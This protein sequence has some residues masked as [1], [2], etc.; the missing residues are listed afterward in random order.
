[1][2]VCSCPA[3]DLAK[4]T[5][6]VV[7]RAMDSNMAGQFESAEAS[8]WREIGCN[9]V[10]L[11]TVEV[12]E[13]RREAEDEDEDEEE[14][15]ERRKRFS[16]GKLPEIETTRGRIE[17][18]QPGSFPTTSQLLYVRSSCS[19]QFTLGNA[20]SPRPSCLG[21]RRGD[22]CTMTGEISTFDRRM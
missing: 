1:M 8:D 21:L 10:Q 14:G 3:W 5:R 11:R 13:C 18:K 19:D 12:G 2:G 17:G 20:A 7:V 9:W 22:G 16:V 6:K 4:V 15:E